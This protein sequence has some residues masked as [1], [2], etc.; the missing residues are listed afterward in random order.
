MRDM[1]AR[2][3]VE[4]RPQ[5][6]SGLREIGG[7]IF[8]E[9]APSWPSVEFSEFVGPWIKDLES[10]KNSNIPPQ[11]EDAADW[12]VFISTCVVCDPPRESLIEFA[13]HGDPYIVRASADNGE[14]PDEVTKLPLGSAAPVRG[15]PSESDLKGVE[16]WLFARVFDE[17]RRDP[18]LLRLDAH[19]VIEEV[20]QNNFDLKAEYQKK[21]RG[22]P[23]PR[24]IEVTGGISKKQVGNAFDKIVGAHKPRGGATGIDMLVA[25]E[26][27]RLYDL[28]NGADPENPRRK[29]W[30]HEKLYRKFDEIPSARAASH[31]VEQGRKLLQN[32]PQPKE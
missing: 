9:S 13:K 6:E 23:R 28:D 29:K 4:A 3:G 15:L 21:S 18:E 27:A 11:F 14:L 20:L 30:T 5:L 24:Q 12:K 1:R 17:I 25:L 32:K 8:P 7:L 10:I 19:E 2:W 16:R 31:Y 26:C 22:L